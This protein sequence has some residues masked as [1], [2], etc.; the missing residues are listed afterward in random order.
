MIR[1]CLFAVAAAVAASLTPTLPVQAQSEEIERIIVRPRSQV[2]R[3][4]LVV[5]DGIRE[6]VVGC[7]E[8]ADLPERAPEVSLRVRFKE[9]GT[10]DGPP[11]ELAREDGGD[12]YDRRYVEALTAARQALYQCE[13]YDFL[14]RSQYQHWQEL[15]LTFRPAP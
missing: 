9:D 14:P 15:I 11:Q 6:H 13:P 1:R 7:L 10:L 12:E 8:R 2:F 5:L 3:P 4:T